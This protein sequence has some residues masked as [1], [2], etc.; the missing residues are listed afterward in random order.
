MYKLP[1]EVNALLKQIE[2]DL[3]VVFRITDGGNAIFAEVNEPFID[4]HTKLGMALTKK[5]LIG[6]DMEDYFR[7]HLG[8]GNEQVESRMKWLD[9]VL[10]SG[11]SFSHTE[12]S[13]HPG[14]LAMELQ[15]V[16]HPIITKDNTYVV[17][18]SQLTLLTKLSDD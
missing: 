9:N 15:S 16:M 6:I 7:F 18:E 13:D 4:F 3:I 17:W 5:D 2:R 12:V 11:E 1:S 14:I 8:F 10:E